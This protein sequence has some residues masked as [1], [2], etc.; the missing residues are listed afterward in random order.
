MKIRYSA[1]FRPFAPVL[2]VGIAFPDASPRT[3][4]TALVDTGADMTHI[5]LQI[6][7]RL[8]A[9]VLYSAVAR[10]NPAAPG[11]PVTVHEV[12][13]IVNELRFPAIEVFGD[14]NE[15]IIVL[16]RNFLNM[17]RIVLDRP[18]SILEI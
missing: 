5:P 4:L 18:K 3:T 15:Q 6:L 13:L 7:K 17:M 10:A 16:G 2:R 12:D 11:Y 1:K 14:E 9:P 8:K